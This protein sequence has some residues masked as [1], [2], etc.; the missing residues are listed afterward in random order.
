MPGSSI[1][2]PRVR[3]GHERADETGRGFRNC[4]AGKSTLRET[5]GRSHRA[6]FVPA[7]PDPVRPGGGAVADDEYLAAH[8]E[9]LRR[10]EWI[11]DGFGS[12]ATAWERFARADTLV[13]L[14]LHLI[15][16][17]WWVTSV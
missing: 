10:D 4:G 14:D 9:L 13:Y 5:P 8:A 15:R 3:R 17:Y 6:S 11:I 16:H 2:I 12:I 7:G 1:S